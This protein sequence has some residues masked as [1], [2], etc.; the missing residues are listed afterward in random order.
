MPSFA[1][2]A[3]STVARLVF[4][5]RHYERLAA[6]GTLV[7]ARFGDD[8]GEMLP[9]LSDVEIIISTWGMP[10]V[11]EQFLA[12]APQLR[13][14]FYA[15]GTVK[16]FVT[17]ALWERGITVSS[18]APANAVPVAEYTVAVIILANKRFWQ[19]MRH[20]RDEA[21]IIEA[22]GNYRRT[23]GIIGASLVGRETLRLLRGYDLDVLLYDPFVTEAEARQFG[24][25]KVELADLMTSADVVSLHAPNL[26]E[27]RHMINAAQLARMKDGATFINTARGALVDEAALLAELQRGR[28][29]AVLDVTDPEPPVSGSP[30][31]SLPNVIYTPHIA[32]SM[33]GECHRMADFA[34]DEAERFLRGESLRNA[35]RPD[36]LATMA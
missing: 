35:I 29:Y 3:P 27:L 26:P 21:N 10:R 9:L 17:P 30:L 11:D 7:D 4:V 36:A 32:G 24:A 28:L 14:I 8:A 31:Y 22:P 23:V 1:L 19:A 33:D 5:A 18:A 20:T 15:A 34:I 6:L 16:N 13:G 25:A 12:R 2:F